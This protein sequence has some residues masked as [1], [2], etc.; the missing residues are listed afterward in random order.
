[1]KYETQEFALPRYARLGASYEREVPAI[2]GRVLFTFD[3][4]FPDDDAVREHIGGEYSYKRMV[5]LRAGYKAGYDSQGATFGLGVVYH[6]IGL[7]YAFLPV[8]NDLGDS[9]RFGL[10]FSF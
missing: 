4:V 2:D 10:N 6:D 3:A 5:S 9:H 1:M 7:D 8:S